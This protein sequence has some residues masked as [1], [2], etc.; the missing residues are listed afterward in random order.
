L[1]LFWPSLSQSP[2]GFGSLLPALA[3][4][5]TP[6]DIVMLRG[7]AQ[8]MPAWRYFLGADPRRVVLM[9]PNGLPALPAALAKPESAVVQAWLCRGS[10]CLA[11]VSE[12]VALRAVLAFPEKCNPV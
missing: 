4:T 3:E 9:L 7:P 2:A 12:Q 11:P 10:T 1:R 8:G 6:P 5:L